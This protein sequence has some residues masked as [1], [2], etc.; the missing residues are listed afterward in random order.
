MMQIH[1]PSASTHVVVV[2]VHRQDQATRAAALL[3]SIKPRTLLELKFVLQV[4]SKAHASVHF[5]C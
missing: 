2:S 1:A 4:G 5:V 3:A